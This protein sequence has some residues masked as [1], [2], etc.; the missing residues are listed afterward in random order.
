[1]P[2]TNDDINQ[3]YTQYGDET[4]RRI[5]AENEVKRLE[6]EIEAL[7]GQPKES[8]EKAE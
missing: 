3:F 6:A 7:K 8:E 1:M 4:M 2:I 5:H